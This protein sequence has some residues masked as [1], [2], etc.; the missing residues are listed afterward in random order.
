MTLTL[1]STAVMG[2]RTTVTDEQ[3]NYRIG[4]LPPG[5][6]S[7]KFELQGFGSVL[8]EGIQM[9]AGFTS[10]VNVALAVGSVAET[11][12][13]VGESP[14]IDVTNAVV[15]TNFT[16]E[17]TS[18]LPTG[19]G[20]LTIYASDATPPGFATLPF[21]ASQTRAL[22]VVTAL[23]QSGEI[24]MQA[25]VAGGGTVDVVVDVMGYFE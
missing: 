2:V 11:I 4:F 13:V 17:L 24:T 15:A 22:F 16:Q 25:S 20:D 9:T 23:S 3:G 7:L 6:Y 10:T 21:N 12:T 18:V 14:I 8:R 1:T 5:S 19:S